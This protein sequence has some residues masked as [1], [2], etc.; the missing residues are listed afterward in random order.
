MSKWAGIATPYRFRLLFRP[1]QRGW[2]ITY[3]PSGF[4]VAEGSDWSSPVGK[5]LLRVL[6]ADHWK[7]KK[8]RIVK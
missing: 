6:E 1:G 5:K 7:R 3:G 8:K 2:A 4:L